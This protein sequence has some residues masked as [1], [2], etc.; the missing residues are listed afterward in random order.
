VP[1]VAGLVHEQSPIPPTQ[2]VREMPGY[3]N[4]R[5]SGGETKR[6]SVAEWSEDTV[7]G[8][9]K[10]SRAASSAAILTRPRAPAPTSI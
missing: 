7:R 9:V 1:L 6:A 5:E 10:L 3:R 4:L 8:A 2:S